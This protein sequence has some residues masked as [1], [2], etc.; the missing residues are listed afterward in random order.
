MMQKIALK[1]ITKFLYPPGLFLMPLL[2]KTDIQPE[3]NEES[4][5]TK[6]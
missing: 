1:V 2:A 4:L 6:Q 5:I 3:L